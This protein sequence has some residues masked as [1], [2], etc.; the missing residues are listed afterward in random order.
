MLKILFLIF[1]IVSGRNI[2]LNENN[3]VSL[4]NEV[5]DESISKVIYELYRLENETNIYIY[6]DTSGGSVDAG[7]KLIETIEYFSQ[8]KNISCIAHHAASM[9][10]VILQA[11]PYRLGLKTSKLM[12]HQISTMLADEKQRLK[13]YMTYINDLEDELITLQA[14]RINISNKRFRDITYHNW[15]LTGIK[16]LKYNVVD[17]LVVV[18]CD[19]SLL[20]THIEANT[21]ISANNIIISTYN[22]CP[23]IYKPINIKYEML[24]N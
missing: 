18:G 14:S 6:I 9:G 7:N 12:Q 15:W 4:T 1:I 10:F 11:C 2:I 13:T 19:N 5:N 24:Y 20:G 22:R 17:E 8:I 3:M 23:L 21:S 16:A